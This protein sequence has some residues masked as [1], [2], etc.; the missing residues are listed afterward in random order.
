MSKR[1]LERKLKEITSQS[2]AEFI[3]QERL[4]RARQL[5]L[6]GSHVTVAEISHA[7]GFKN[8]KYFSRLYKNQFNQS[9]AEVLKT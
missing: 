6:D 1:Q 2:P 4:S 3:R 5:L 9:P 8:V 7:V